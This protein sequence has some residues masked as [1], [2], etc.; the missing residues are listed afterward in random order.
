MGM[1]MGYEVESRYVLAWPEGS[2]FHGMEVV[3]G[4]M[5]IETLMRFDEIGAQIEAADMDQPDERARAFALT[6][7]RGKLI[8]DH[9]VSWN[10]ERRGTPI[11]FD[12][13]GVLSLER[14]QII[15][16]QNG[17]IQAVTEVPDP[18]PEESDDMPPFQEELIPMEPST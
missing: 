16:I 13:S 2:P 7:E 10:L 15:A 11:E 5:S 12:A 14:K 9:G 3:M 4:S 1:T 17:W 18:L 6:R 8:A